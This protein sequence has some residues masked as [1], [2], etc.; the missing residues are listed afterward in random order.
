MREM[1]QTVED[2]KGIVLSSLSK[3]CQELAVR[4]DCTSLS[5]IFALPECYIEARRA[6]VALQTWL[7][8]DTKYTS[9]I[10]Q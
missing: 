8:D 7:I 3:E 6:I 1:P 5:Y 2:T 9:F 10:Q 4:S